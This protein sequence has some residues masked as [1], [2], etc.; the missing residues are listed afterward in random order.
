MTN[1]LIYARAS[2]GTRA[3]ESLSI[4]DQIEMMEEHARLNSWNI[5]DPISDE[6]ES[7]ESARKARH[8]TLRRYL[9]KHGDVHIVMIAGDQD[10]S[11]ADYAA[12]I[13]ILDHHGISILVVNTRLDEYDESTVASPAR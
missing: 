1:C 7:V 13:T 11:L 10:L 6:E 5:L 8:L 2:K 12:I 4:A 9:A 3:P